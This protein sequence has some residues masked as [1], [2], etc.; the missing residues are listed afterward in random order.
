LQDQQSNTIY[1]TAI[2]LPEKPGIISVSVPN[3]IPLAVNKRYRWFLT[4]DCDPQ[5]D[6]SPTYVEG[7]IKR[8]TLDEKVTE[9]LATATPLQRFDIYLQNGIWHEALKTLSQLRQDKPEDKAIQE[10]WQSLLTSIRLED[11]ASQPLRSNQP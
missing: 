7:V 1:Q 10:Q 4:V 6:S 9:K 3:N 2:A 11:V 8:V 5:N